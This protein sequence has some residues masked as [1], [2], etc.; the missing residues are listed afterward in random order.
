MPKSLQPR[1]GGRPKGTPSKQAILPREI[2]DD[3][4]RS[5]RPAQQAD[6]LSRLGRAI[7][8]LE[9]DDP[10]GAL[11]EAE[12]AKALAPRSASVR[13]VLGMAYY[14]VGRWQDAVTELK[15]YKRITGRTD[16]NHLIADCYRA[17]GKPEE[18]VPLADE[19][20]RDRGASNEAKAESVIVAASALADRARYAEALALLARAKTRDDVAADYT[21]RLWYV[22]GDVLAKAGRS[23]EAASEFRK[24]MRH[25]PAAFDAAERLAELG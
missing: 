12:R 15:A 18:C 17:L 11:P 6:V 25:D 10:R 16:Q 3:V 9:R 13:E 19:V 2:E 1:A 4:R 22:R 20:L 23:D 14:G 5:A 8:R 24:I 7:D 21:L